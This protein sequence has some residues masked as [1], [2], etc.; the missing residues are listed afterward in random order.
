[1]S[2][3]LPRNPVALRRLHARATAALEHAA[4]RG[5]P[6]LEFA[7]FGRRLGWRLLLRGFGGGLSLVLTPVNAVRYFEFPFALSCLPPAPRRCLDVGSP[8]L[9]SLYVA[10]LNPA[11]ST[12]MINPDRADAGTTAAIV[13]KLGIDRVRVEPRDVGSLAGRGDRYDCVWAISV[14]EHV[15]GSDDDRS[16]VRRMRAALG[17]RGRLILT[18]PVDRGYSEEYRD[19]SPYDVPGEV[20]GAGRFFQRWYDAAA[21]RERIVA[22]AGAEPAV[23]RW[24]GET[25]PGTWAAYERRWTAEGVECTVDDP[26][27]IADRYREYD[28]WERMPGKGVCGLMFEIP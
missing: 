4:R 14:I 22:S 8:R 1:M 28:A 21:I 12:L 25:S 16:A 19:R 6:G 27:E 20:S 26:R 18:V 15:S 3:R 2:G 11:V 10:D 7:M 9:F 13:S 17:P 5:A 24:F 23:V